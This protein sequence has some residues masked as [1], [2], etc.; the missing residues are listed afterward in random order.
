[1]CQEWTAQTPHEPYFT[2]GNSPYAGL[3]GNYCRNPNNEPGGAWCYTTNPD[4]RWQY[5]VVPSC[6]ATANPTA[7]PTDQ[8][9]KVPTKRPTVDPTEQPMGTPSK[10]PT[11][12]PTT[13]PAKK[14]A[15]APPTGEVSCEL[16]TLHSPRPLTLIFFSS[17]LVPNR[18]A[19]G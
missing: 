12:E 14:E 11:D 19:Y 10:A 4:K 13:E 16:T 5:C 1:V 18:E 3:E 15:T 6:G 8:P 7:N 17:T 9:T 2:P